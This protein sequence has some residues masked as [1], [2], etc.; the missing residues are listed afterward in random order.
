MRLL[1]RWGHRWPPI[2]LVTM[3]LQLSLDVEATRP[4]LGDVHEMA[5]EENSS[6]KPLDTALPGNAPPSMNGRIDT[7]L[8]GSAPLAQPGRV[9]SGIAG[10]L[11]GTL[12][13]QNNPGLP[14]R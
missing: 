13:G 5:A 4:E 2:A 6:Q 14:G 1:L 10:R 8:A 3:L 11:T 12:P 9:D 7:G